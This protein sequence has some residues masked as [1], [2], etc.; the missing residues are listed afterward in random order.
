MIFVYR[1]SLRVMRR[2]FP[3][4]TTAMLIV[5]TCAPDCDLGFVHR[6][7]NRCGACSVTMPICSRI[8]LPSHLFAV[9]RDAE[10]ML[11][12][13]SSSHFL[14]FLGVT[15]NSRWPLLAMVPLLCWKSVSPSG[16]DP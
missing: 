13:L 5:C 8:E 12:L 15:G 4:S 7:V 14:A 2:V 3:V 1:S 9:H 10:R 6:I 16:C 11:N